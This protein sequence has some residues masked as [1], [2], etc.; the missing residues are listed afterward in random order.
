[1]SKFLR[2]L[3]LVAVASIFLTYFL[4]YRYFNADFGSTWEFI[5]TRPSVFWYNT[6]IMF[7]IALFFS[8]IFRRPWFGL[9]ITWSAVAILT[10]INSNKLLLRGAPLL[11]EDFQLADQAASLT[12]FVDFWS[13]VRLIVGCLFMLISCILLDYATREFFLPPEHKVKKSAFWLRRQL[14]PRI[15]LVGIAAVGLVTSTDFIRNRTSSNDQVEWLNTSF[16]AWN[17]TINYE[18]N[19]FLMGFIYNIGQ[20]EIEQP[21]DYSEATMAELASKYQATAATKNSERKS[22][23]TQDYNIVVILNESFYDP[24]F[25]RESYPY[26]GD[27]TPTLHRLMKSYPSGY[28]YSPSY[29][30]GTAN[31]EFEVDTGF[32]NFGL[33]ATPYTD[34]LPRLNRIASTASYAKDNGYQTVAIHP[35]SGAMYKRNYALKTEG[36]D[37]FITEEQMDF[38][39]RDSKS[40]YINDRSS[41]QQILKV[42]R[43][44]DAKQ[45][46]SLITMQNH[47]P[48]AGA[49]YEN[50]HFPQRSELNRAYEVQGYYETV[51]RSDQYLGEF[52]EELEQSNEKTVVL[53][54]GDHA[55]GILDSFISSDDPEINKLAHLTPY[56]VYAN[57]D[58]PSMKAARAQVAEPILLYNPYTGQYYYDYSAVEQQPASL[59]LPTTT[60]NCLANTLL[61]QLQVK[62]PAYLYLVADTC[63]QYPILANSYFNGAPPTPSQTLTNYELLN[64]DALSGNQYFWRD[65]DE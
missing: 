18:H 48:Y 24:E 25:L 22:L 9:G 3:G 21:A 30:G 46:V 2:R 43:D 56:F 7:F 23:S 61:D 10:F 62:K 52:I 53:F 54:Y 50:I 27:A 38:T 16:L 45:F 64:Y 40:E 12:K 28:M 35:F 14:L 6:L 41:Y 55:P 65:S 63:T 60:P 31:I 1:M 32:T 15:V 8:S 4:Q 29:G 17:Q 49:D 47:A 58:L 39:E 44:R 37:E 13:I 33:N 51:Y 5:L 20:A 57:F 26:E 59:K 36:F 34:I 11:P 19:G 42:I